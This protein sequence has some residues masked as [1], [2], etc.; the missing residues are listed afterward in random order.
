[1]V[2]YCG[3]CYK[4][5]LMLFTLLVA[6][7]LNDFGWSYA[8]S[9]V[10]TAKKFYNIGHWYCTGTVLVLCWYCA[11]TVQ[12]CTGAILLLHVYYTGF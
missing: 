12:H 2:L 9:D 8:N 7:F 1:M 10:I 11:G 3:Q 4:T 5:F 6:Y